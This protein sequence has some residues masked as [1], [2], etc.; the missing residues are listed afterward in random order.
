MSVEGNIEKKPTMTFETEIECQQSE[1]KILKNIDNKSWEGVN[2]I[3]IG[4]ANMYRFCLRIP[5]V[6]E[7]V[8]CLSPKREKRTFHIECGCVR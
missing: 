7:F 2:N 5:N 8:I 1:I 6:L 4:S 3:D